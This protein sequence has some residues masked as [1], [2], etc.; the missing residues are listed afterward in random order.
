MA[1]WVRDPNPVVVEIAKPKSHQASSEEDE[2]IIINEGYPE[3]DEIQIRDEVFSVSGMMRVN[4]DGS[5]FAA[6]GTQNKEDLSCKL[7][8]G[9]LSRVA[10]A[11]FRVHFGGKGHNVNGKAV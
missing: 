8:L 9:L 11:I 1:T 3:K 6:R 4:Q 10:R 2:I 7:L 5:I